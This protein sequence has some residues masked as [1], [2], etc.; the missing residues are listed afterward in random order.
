MW[1]PLLVAEHWHPRAARGEIPSKLFRH[2]YRAA[3]LET[4]DQ[5]GPVSVCTVAKGLRHGGEAM[6]PTV[7]G[8]LGHV[9]QRSG[10][11]E[12]RAAAHAAK[13]GVRLEALR[14]LGLGTLLAPRK[15]TS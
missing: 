9:R 4:L 1:R 12:Y 3:R 13:L 8:H 15:Q 6:V 2:T 14:S 11:V 10:V 7:Y 5:G